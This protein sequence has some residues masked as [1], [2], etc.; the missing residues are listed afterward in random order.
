MNKN[1]FF[2]LV[3]KVLSGEASPAE[4]KLFDS[5]MFDQEYR[6]L[7][8]YVKK[9]WHREIR[10]PEKKFEFA[11]SLEKLRAKI[12]KAEQAKENTSII[13]MPVFKTIGYV[14]AAV[15]L[16]LT[17]GF[18]GKTLLFNENASKQTHFLSY[19]TQRGERKLIELPDGSK[20]YLNAETSIR[21]PSDFSGN[22]RNINLTGEAFFEVKRE[23]IRRPF[24]VHSADVTTTVLGTSFNISAFPDKDAHITVATGKV[25]VANQ[26]D[27]KRVI[28]T[29]GEQAIYDKSGLHKTTVDVSA[30]TDWRNGILRF[31]GIPLD[32]AIGQME[33]W[34]DVTIEYD[35]TLLD[36]SIRGIYKNESLRQVLEDMQFMLELKYEFVNDSLIVIRE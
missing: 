18:L 8:E 20:V 1:A 23:D 7:Y 35:S 15:I 2:E 28:L 33:R 5:Y 13:K 9:E 26:L 21:Y 36:R 6:N 10:H 30:Y 22:V 12:K 14:A 19:K 29:K 11:K 32:K 31:D 3:T 4:K 27:N 25:K 16:L 24:S 34:Y 17:V